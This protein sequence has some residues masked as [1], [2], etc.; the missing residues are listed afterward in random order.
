MMHL[1]D[2][3]IAG[4]SKVNNICSLM[5]QQFPV[6]SQSYT[7][8]LRNRSFSSI[9]H[10]NLPYCSLHRL[11]DYIGLTYRDWPSFFRELTAARYSEKLQG[12]YIHPVA[13]YPY[14]LIRLWRSTASS[15]PPLISNQ[16]KAICLFGCHSYTRRPPC[17]NRARGY[18][19]QSFSQWRLFHGSILWLSNASIYIL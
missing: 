8:L 2:M 11:A 6:F 12:W 7:T 4:A 5:Y 14:R 13:A 15:Y 16:G 10:E 17:A 18:V 3:K 9:K 1:S 19:K